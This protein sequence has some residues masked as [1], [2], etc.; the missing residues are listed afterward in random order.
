MA[1]AARP[2]VRDTG[3]V[4]CPVV[5]GGPAR[6]SHSPAM[7]PNTIAAIWETEDALNRMISAATTAIDARSGPGIACAPQRVLAVIVIRAFGQRIEAFEMI[8]M[9]SASRTSS[10]WRRNRSVIGI[11]S[12]FSASRNSGV[13]T[14]LE[15]I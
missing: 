7:P 1:S 5:A 2:A 12:G 13:S 3:T 10:G 4:T 6:Q 9:P 15:R 8:E 11:V 14:I